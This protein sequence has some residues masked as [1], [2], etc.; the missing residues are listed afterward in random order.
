M[1]AMGKKIDQ[2]TG[3]DSNFFTAKHRRLYAFSYTDHFPLFAEA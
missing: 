3:S 1:P 2:S